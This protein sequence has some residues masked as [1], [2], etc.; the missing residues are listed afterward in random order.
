M[1]TFL[2][3]VMLLLS[4]LREALSMRDGIWSP[5]AFKIEMISFLDTGILAS[6]R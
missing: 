5:L 1:K 2:E 3:K 4:L 6:S